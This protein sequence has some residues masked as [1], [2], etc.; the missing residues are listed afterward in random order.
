MPVE[1]GQ[2]RGQE[3]SVTCKSHEY[4]TNSYGFARR[5]LGRCFAAPAFT[6]RPGDRVKQTK[7]Q[8][9]IATL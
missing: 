3:C 6:R 7:R 5:L 1:P 2:P 9:G 4:N 8:A